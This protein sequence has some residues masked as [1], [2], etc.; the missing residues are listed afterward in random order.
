MIKYLLRCLLI[1]LVGLFGGTR[2]LAASAPVGL[3]LQLQ[4]SKSDWQQTAGARHSVL[5][6]RASLQMAEQT[7]KRF[8]GALEFSAMDLRLKHHGI[9]ESFNAQGLA[10]VLRFPL[11]SESPFQL[12]TQIQAG[13]NSGDATT[14]G[15]ESL[16]DWWQWQAQ[17]QA[18]ARWDNL[19]LRPYLRAS[20]L[21][22]DYSGH[23][24][25]SDWSFELTPK[26][27]QG[28]S[29]DI[30][31]DRYS[32]IGLYLETGAESGGGIWFAREFDY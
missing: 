13:F 26:I 28:V 23:S 4:S 12:D 3:S 31:V 6:R 30:F 9:T 21:Q 25:I 16:L 15:S 22:G 8:T 17:I 32:Y 2:V 1:L 20:A 27:T 18:S 24:S 11:Y 19:R 7:S 10:L 5:I 14:P 29:L